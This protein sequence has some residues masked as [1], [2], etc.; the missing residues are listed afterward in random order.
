MSRFTR[1]LTAA[2]VAGALAMPAMADAQAQRRGGGSSGGSSGGSASSGGSSGGASVAVPRAEAPRPSPPPPSTSSAPARPRSS[3]DRVSGSIGG[4][5]SSG[6]AVRSRDNQAIRGTAVPRGSVPS[7]PRPPIDYDYYRW[8]PW[9]P[10]S[11]WGYG[12]FGYSPWNYGYGPW[13]WH[14]YGWYDPFWYGPWSFG[15][16]ATYWPSSGGGSYDYDDGYQDTIGSIRLR[17]NPDNARV[18]V[19]GALVGVAE[20]FG[21]LNNHLELPAGRHQL[22][23]RADGYEPETV[24]VDVRANRVRTTRVKLDRID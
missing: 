20:E 19:D 6:A 21:G 4:G 5:A 2:F 8:Y 16:G 13:G 14:R 18:Y 7:A 23:L 22:E 10:A 24:E 12:Y 11:S 17:V 15:Y 1:L 3:P 9:Y